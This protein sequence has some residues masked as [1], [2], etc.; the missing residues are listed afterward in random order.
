MEPGFHR[1]VYEEVI[2]NLNDIG[3]SVDDLYSTQDRGER[4]LLA[5][6]VCRKL[7]FVRANVWTIQP[8]GEANDV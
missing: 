4:A 2:D 7:A 8:E 3:Q 5:R 6:Y 1:K